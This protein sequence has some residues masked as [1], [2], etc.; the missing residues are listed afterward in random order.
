LYL[1]QTFWENSLH[2]EN[3]KLAF[4]L[5]AIFFALVAKLQDEKAL[6]LLIL[7]SEITWG[8]QQSPLIDALPGYLM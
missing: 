5:S 4:S 2:Q 6:R 8:A 7:V 1:D 3:Q